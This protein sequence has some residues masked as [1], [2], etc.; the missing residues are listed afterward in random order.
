MGDLFDSSKS[1]LKLVYSVMRYPV[2]NNIIRVEVFMI[3]WSL[4]QTKSCYFYSP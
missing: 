2:F 3:K 1:K 4:L